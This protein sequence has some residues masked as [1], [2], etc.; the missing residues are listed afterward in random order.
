MARVLKDERV[1]DRVFE[2]GITSL[3]LGVKR[4]KL[5]RI[6]GGKRFWDITFADD[7]RV[8]WSASQ[9]GAYLLGVEHGRKDGR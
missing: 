8:V 2:S 4:W 1:P 5:T 9:L 3:G 7:H 6:S